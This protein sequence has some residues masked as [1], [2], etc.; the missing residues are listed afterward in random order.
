[1][2]ARIEPARRQTLLPEPRD[3]IGAHGSCPTHCSRP[4]PTST[5]STSPGAM[6]GIVTAI[7]PSFMRTI[8]SVPGYA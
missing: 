5:M 8:T 6:S 7:S 1:M 3:S 2:I 4:E